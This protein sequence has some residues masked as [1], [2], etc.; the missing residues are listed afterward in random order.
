MG[1]KGKR[2]R[3]GALV[4]LFVL[5]GTVDS[6]KAHLITL[7]CAVLSKSDK[8]IVRLLPKDVPL[9]HFRVLAQM[10]MP[11]GREA[12]S[13]RLARALVLKPADVSAALEAL[14]LK[15]FVRPVGE[16]DAGPGGNAGASATAAGHATRGQRPRT[17]ELS[18]AGSEVADGLLASVSE[19]LEECRMKVPPHER[20]L[21]SEM[22]ANALNVPGSFY[23]GRN[24]VSPEDVIA[25]PPYR[26]T[27]FA[28]IRQAISAAVKSSLGLSLTDFRFLLELYPKK[29]GVTKMLRAK[30]MV[31][32][33]RTGRS[34]VT[35][36][37]LRLEEDGY[38]E[39]IPD[40][41][42]ARGIL[43]RLTG[44]GTAAVQE[45]GEDIFTV[46][47]S[48]SNEHIDDRRIIHALKLLLEGQEEAL[49]RR[50][51]TRARA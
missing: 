40:P 50:G 42:D 44:T 47:V 30:D 25:F 36:A 37:S 8:G 11:D 34:Y 46:F 9:T 2:I 33:L 28:M 10:T 7:W 23:A 14:E 6:S 15:G 5:G 41:D 20:A 19:F 21:L 26:V 32:Y 43:F 12:T 4:R 24:A 35:T 1:Q 29:R 45:V 38:I 18:P 16:G 49:A 39:R 13:I 51:V 3:L 27:A 48:L 22:L 17:W 31:V